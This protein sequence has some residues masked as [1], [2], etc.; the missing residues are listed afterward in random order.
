MRLFK[1]SVF[2]RIDKYNSF[3]NIFY[4]FQQKSQFSVDLF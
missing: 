3:L 2:G 4:A 1:M